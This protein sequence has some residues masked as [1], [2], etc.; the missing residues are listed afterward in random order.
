M[1]L[2]CGALVAGGV[3]AYACVRRFGAEGEGTLA[4]WDP[5]T[6]LVV[7]GPYAYVRNPMI[8][9]VLLIL[10]GEALGLRSLPHLEWAGIFF[11]MNALYIPLIE[12]SGLRARFGAE[13]EE[14]AR[15]VPR[16]IPRPTPWRGENLADRGREGAR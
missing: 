12:E 8:S 16:L 3:L 13:Y 7:V 11:V 4:P 5:P 15:A 9:G 10:V 1:A 2:G 14:Y 6:N